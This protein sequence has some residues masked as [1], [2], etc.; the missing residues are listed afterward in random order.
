MSVKSSYALLLAALV[1]VPLTGVPRPAR[2]ANLWDIYTLALKNDPAYLQ[3]QADYQAALEDRPIARAGYLPDLTLNAAK[4]KARSYGTAFRQSGTNAAGQPVYTSTYDS[5]SIRDTEYGLQ[6]TQPLFNWAAWERIRQADAAVAEAQAVFL[7]AQQA[8]IVN[9]ATAYFA[10]ITARDTLAADHT[11]TQATGQQLAEAKAEFGVGTMPVINVEQAQAG[12]DQ[13]V[14]NEIAAQQ[15]V[16]N[17]EEALRV[18][19]GE[20]AG[21]LQAPSAKLPLAAPEPANPELWVDQAGKLN[22]NLRA[23]Q[24]AA[25]VAART[26]GIARAGHYPTLGLTASYDRNQLNGGSFPGTSNTTGISKASGAGAVTDGSDIRQRELG[27]NF[28]LPLF[29]GGGVS[30]QVTQA[31]RQLDSAQAQ[32]QFV[33]RQTTQQART[34]YLGVLAGIS[35]VQALRQTVKSSQTALDSTEVGLQVG[36]ET[37]VDVLLAVQN[38]ALAQTQFAQARDR[39]LINRLALKQAVGTVDADDL[40]AISALLTVPAPVPSLTP[41]TAAPSATTRPGD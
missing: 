39:Y 37:M 32:V 31:E 28:N 14:A 21:E 34:A 6:L 7:A 15:Q 29:A 41:P 8:L 4:S 20:P 10:V 13:A 23:A 5:L 26:V 25:E 17:A 30:A 9:T 11:A 19:T 12:Y 18:I 24:A 35:Q 38:L 27:V 40:K 1:A 22:P 33:S 36:N 3:A 16:T 2:G